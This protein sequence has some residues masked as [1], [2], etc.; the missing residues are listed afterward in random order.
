MEKVSRLTLIKEIQNKWGGYIVWDSANKTVSLRSGNEWQPYNGFQIRY[1]KN[2]K[3][4][5]RTQS[6][7]LVTKLYAFGHDDLDIASVNDGKKYITNFSYID[8]EFTAIYKNQDIYDP[9]ELLEKATVELELMCRPR[10]LYR[11]KIADL[12]TLP[13]Y[14]HEEFTL[15]DMV[16]VIDPSV[17][18]DSPRVRIIRHKYN[19]FMPW[20][21]ELEIG[22]PLERFEE[23][24]KAAFGVTGFIDGKFTEGGRFS[25]HSIEDMTIVDGKIISIEAKKIT[26]NEAK[27]TTAQIEN[28]EVGRNVVM[29]PDATISW[30]QVTS[31]P[32]IP[33]LPSYIKSTYIDSTRI[34]SPLIIGGEV[35]GGSITS[36]TH[37][38]VTENA[39]IGR[40]LYLDIAGSYMGG[41]D[42]DVASIDVD[43]ASGAMFLEADG[44]IRANGHRID[45][46][47]VAVFG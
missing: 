10:Y 36:D 11:V 19:L 33:T 12:R 13:E 40:K 47:P 14:E 22:D 5:T 28:L 43:P 42:F 45:V 34:E 24:L 39:Y 29:G 4:I 26:T 46:P 31:K 37:I 6:N 16:D 9:Q 8:K 1:A 25:G 21:C 20:D 3:H 32:S 27:I 2:L 7:R 44:A 18:P 15:G 38:N 23:N 17:A 30:S 35:R 41:I